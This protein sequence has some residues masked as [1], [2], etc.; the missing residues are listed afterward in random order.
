MVPQDTIDRSTD[1]REF[2][3]GAPVNPHR[4]MEFSV[5]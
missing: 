4:C 1:T 2:L 5:F 3:S